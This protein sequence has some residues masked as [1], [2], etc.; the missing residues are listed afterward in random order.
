ME[1]HRVADE[2]ELE[3]WLVNAPA[4]LAA[5]LA[6]TPALE[7]VITKVQRPCCCFR[8]YCKSM[9][10][11]VGG[12]SLRKCRSPLHMQPLPMRLCFYMPVMLVHARTPSCRNVRVETEQ[13]LHNL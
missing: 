13:E 10:A 1:A 3:A 7:D 11:M 6:A 4:V 8:V 5:A 12:A 9:P 2:A